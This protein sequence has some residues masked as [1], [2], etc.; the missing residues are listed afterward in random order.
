MGRMHV[1]AKWSYI[2]SP[3]PHHHPLP[4]KRPGRCQKA[5]GGRRMKE[6]GGAGGHDGVHLSHVIGQVSL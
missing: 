1:T 3:E 4:Q 5:Y 2:Y 6:P